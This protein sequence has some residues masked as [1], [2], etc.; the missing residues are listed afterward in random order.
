V[1]GAHAY[2]LMCRSPVF[3]SM[4]AGNLIRN[5]G[6]VISIDL[7]GVDPEAF[8]EVL[9]FALLVFVRLI[10]HNESTVDLILNK[11]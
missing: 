9:R 1:I 8:K 7:P 10:Y 4:F 6:S 11:T 3:E 5:P 2:M